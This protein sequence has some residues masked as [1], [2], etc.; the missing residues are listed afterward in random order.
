[1]AAIENQVACATRSQQL[2]AAIDTDPV[3]FD[4]QFQQYRRISIHCR[5]EAPC[6]IK[7]EKEAGCSFETVHLPVT[8]P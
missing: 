6:A 4:D 1:M 7:P 5:V 2:S 3:C 8:I